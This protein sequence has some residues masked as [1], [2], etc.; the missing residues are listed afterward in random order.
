MRINKQFFTLQ[1]LLV[2][3]LIQIE[4]LNLLKKSKSWHKRRLFFLKQRVNIVNVLIL[5]TEENVKRKQLKIR[6]RPCPISG[7]HAKIILYY[8]YYFSSDEYKKKDNFFS[9]CL[10]IK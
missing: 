8:N 9:I 7:V 4:K 3:P 10:N 1:S 6:S 5:L 2:T